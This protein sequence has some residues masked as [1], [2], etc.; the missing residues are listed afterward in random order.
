MQ[1][2]GA[3][4]DERE[5]HI[6]LPLAG[7]V[8][9]VAVIAAGATLGDR[10][11]PSPS[12]EREGSITESPSSTGSRRPCAGRFRSRCAARARRP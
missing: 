1:I 6:P 8:R 12:R 2:A 7:G 3:V 10:P 9:G 4:I 11:S 5:G